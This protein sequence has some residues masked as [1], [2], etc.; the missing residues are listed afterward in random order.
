MFIDRIKNS[1]YYRMKWN[2]LGVPFFRR[3]NHRL[4]RI[5]INGKVINLNYPVNEQ[6]VH[7]HE[8]SLIYFD[9]CYDL[10]RLKSEPKTIVDIGGNIGF[11]P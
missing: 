6:S 9:D 1:I 7:E 11:F 10:S 2:D 3:K 4:K 5:C 8:L